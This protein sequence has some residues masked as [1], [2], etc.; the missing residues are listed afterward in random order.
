MPVMVVS[1]YLSG[2]VTKDVDD[3]VA[4]FEVCRPQTFPSLPLA[5]TLLDL[6]LLTSTA[7]NDRARRVR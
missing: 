2:N 3:I 5:L 4:H 7:H 6:L 1:I